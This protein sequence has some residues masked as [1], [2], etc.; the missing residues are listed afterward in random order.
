LELYRTAS[1]EQLGSDLENLKLTKTHSQ[2]YKPIVYGRNLIKAFNF[3]KNQIIQ[4]ESREE[5]VSAITNSRVDRDD[6]HTTRQNI[7]FHDARGKAFEENDNSMI[8]G[9][10]L[11]ERSQSEIDF[12][13]VFEIKD[14]DYDNDTCT[15]RSDL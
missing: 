1:Q 4:E 5:S 6:C 14:V 9:K 8:S 13:R 7:S 10:L 12:D 11:D 2:D 3:D 15:L